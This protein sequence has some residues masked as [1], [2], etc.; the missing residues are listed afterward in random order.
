MTQGLP[1]SIQSPARSLAPIYKNLSSRKRLLGVL[2]RG[3]YG[4]SFP[5]ESQPAG[6]LETI[7]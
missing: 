1:G 2:V 5:S 7:K 6:W 3:E 4:Q